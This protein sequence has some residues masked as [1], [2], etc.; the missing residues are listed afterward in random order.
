MKDTKGL[1]EK[2]TTALLTLLTKALERKVLNSKNAVI[3]DTETEK[4]TEI[5]NLVMHQN[6]Q[7][8]YTFQILDKPIRN[9]MTM[10]RKQGDNLKQ[11]AESSV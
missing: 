3:Y 6:A 8:E 11:T 10:R 1:Q 2:E 5:K 9:S 4:I 7:G